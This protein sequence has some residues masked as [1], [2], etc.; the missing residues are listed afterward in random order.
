MVIVSLAGLV[1]CPA[2]S[3]APQ[4]RSDVTGAPGRLAPEQGDV[5]GSVSWPGQF[6]VLARAFTGG[7]GLS[8]PL[9]RSVHLEG[10]AGMAST[11]VMGHVGFRHTYW[12]PRAGGNGLAAD[13]EGGI[14][15][16]VGGENWERDCDDGDE[17]TSVGPDWQKRVAAGGYLGGG[18]R[19]RYADVVAPFARIR[20]QVSGA[21]QAPVTVWW[22][23]RGGVEFYPRIW[24]VALFLGTTLQGYFSGHDSRTW[25]TFDVGISMAIPWMPR[26]GYTGPAGLKGSTEVSG[27]SPLAPWPDL[28]EEQGQV[29]GD[30]HA[31]DGR[32]QAIFG[33]DQQ[34]I[35]HEA[36]GLR[37]GRGPA[38]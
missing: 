34:V 26:E 25:P 8:I 18:V 36:G 29:V 38:L 23:I 10:G 22:D 4:I 7:G 6:D 17:S 2:P 13:V 19:H 1:G 37:L 32:G 28:H 3:Y 11:W 15:G 9:G 27:P 35:V 14:G 30:G 16:G 24:G 31:F 21:Q 12:Q 5:H 20:F 33:E